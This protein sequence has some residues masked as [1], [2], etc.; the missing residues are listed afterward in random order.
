MSEFGCLQPV[1]FKAYHENN[2]TENTLRKRRSLELVCPLN[3][4]NV[5]YQEHSFKQQYRTAYLKNGC[6]I[7]D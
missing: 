4:G 7:E 1:A 5:Q 2:N 6:L 3:T